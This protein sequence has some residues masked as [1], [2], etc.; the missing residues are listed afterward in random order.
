MGTTLFLQVFNIIAMTSISMGFARE[1]CSTISETYENPQLVLDPLAK[2]IA[3]KMS[4][5]NPVRLETTFFLF[6]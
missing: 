6:A 1:G 3:E 5:K 4:S 2:E